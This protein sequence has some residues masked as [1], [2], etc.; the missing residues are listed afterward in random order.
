MGQLYLFKKILSFLTGGRFFESHNIEEQIQHLIDVGEEAG[1][2][3]EHE[4]EMIQGIFELRD[5]MAREIMLPRIEITC[6]R[7]DTPIQEILDLVKTTGH[8]RYPIIQPD[9]DNIVGLLHV[10]DIIARW[11]FEGD[12]FSLSDLLRPCHFIPENRR[13]SDILLDFQKNRFHMAI[14]TDEYGG[15]SGL[16]TIEDILEEIVGDIQ[17]EHDVEETLIRNIDSNTILVD[18]RTDIEDLEEHLEI[19]LP[20]GDY[21]S[22][23]GFIISLVDRVPRSG[24]SIS[25]D[26][27]EF[28]IEKADQRRVESVKIRRVERQE[29]ATSGG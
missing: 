20:E 3:S 5:T 4:G 22:V 15:T 16:I 27:I 14:V 1:Q 6:I 8:S 23:G 11:N 10:K 2:I 17:D 12:G 29:S 19:S 28:I 7:A 25:F 9:I 21:E 26:S 24:E 13:I 18:A